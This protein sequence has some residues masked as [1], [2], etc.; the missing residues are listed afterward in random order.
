MPSVFSLLLALTFLA[1]TPSLTSPS[2]DERREA[3]RAAATLGNREAVPQ[4]FEAYKKE[5]RSDIRREIVDGLARIRDASAIPALSQALL[6]DYSKSVRLRAVDAFLQLYIPPADAGGFF[7]RVTAIFTA[8]ERPVVAPNVAV[9]PEVGNALAV[10]LATDFEPEVRMEAAY[11]LGTLQMNSQ[12]EVLVTA[13]EGP[14]NHEASNVRVAAI[15]AIGVLGNKDGGAA[16]TRLLRDDDNHVVE[17]SIRAIG[18]IGY[19]DAFPVLSNMYRAD[20]DDDVS[21]LSLEAIAMMRVPDARPILEAGLDDREDV[22]R[23]ISAEGLARLD[24]PP[25]LFSQRIITERDA[26]VRLA[27]AFALV[28]SDQPQYLSQLIEA[29]DTRRSQQAETYLFELGRYEGKLSALFPHLRNPDPDIRA[30]LVGV[31]GRIGSPEARPYV[32]PL[33][34]DRDTRVMEAAVEAMRRLN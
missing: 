5:P 3:I 18:R 9:A 34:Q 20:Y 25:S 29:L 32:Q 23:Q 12:L 13:A 15:Q 11:A 16:L 24:S 10:A 7:D 26:S 30:R 33:T 22:I 2:P 1:Q 19:V 28:A 31:M 21:E 4:F 8:D 27:L 6:T 17:E 14:W